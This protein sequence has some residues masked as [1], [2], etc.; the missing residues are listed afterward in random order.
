M[1]M[2]SSRSQLYDAQKTARARW[3]AVSELWHDSTK[4]EFEE[5]TWEPLD[6][7]TSDVLRSMDQ[8]AILFA[9]IR[10]ECEYEG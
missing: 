4:Q 6:R 9:Q 1:R 2:G 7:Q 10:Q 5:K 8:L 3:D